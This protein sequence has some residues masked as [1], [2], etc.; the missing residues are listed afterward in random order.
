MFSVV[1]PVRNEAL[2]L[3]EL[4]DCLMP[5][6]NSIPLNFEIIFVNDGSSDN[7]LEFLLNK[8]AAIPELKIIDLSRNFGKEAALYAGILN[9]SGDCIISIDADLQDPVELIPQM[10]E[11][12]LQGYEV[13]TTVRA[14]RKT[15]NYIKRNTS[16]IFYKFINKISDTHLIPHAGDYRLLD[17][18]AVDA[19]LDLK[20]RVRFNK[21]LFA[22][23]G[24]KEKIL[25][26]DR[27]PRFNGETKW[28]Y[29]KLFRFAIDGIT[30]FSTYPLEIWFYL[31]IIISGIGFLYAIYYFIKTIILGIDVPGYPSLLIFILFFCGLQMIGI[32]MLG[33]YIGR[34][35]TESKRRPI[36]IARKIY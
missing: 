12:W 4:F 1:I 26:Y 36:F 22:W 33:K 11:Y 30:S 5:I 29:I 23:I 10:I 34:I 32:G 14:S 16:N 25:Y 6:L 35:F 28:S 27:N 18:I 9:S 15:D 3:P 19:F 24:F 7:T 31:G 8:K 20:E 2:V 13:I 21:G 17:R